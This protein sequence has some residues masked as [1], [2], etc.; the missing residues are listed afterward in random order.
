MAEL[1]YSPGAILRESIQVIRGVL[2]EELAELTVERVVFGLFFTGVKLG[3]GYC[4]VCYTPIKA[5]PEAVCCPSSARA[6][7]L[8]GKLK[9]RKA[10]ECMEEV[11]SA[12]PL[13]KTMGI[14]VM[15]ALSAICRDRTPPDYEVISGVDAFDEAVIAED[16]EVVVVG[17]LAPL[18]K[19]LKKRK[20]PF[21]VLEMDSS[22]LKKDELPFYAPAADAPLK[23]PQADVLV[24]TGT[25]LINDTLEGLLALAK[26]GAQVI[27]VGPT[28][29]MLP[30][31]FFLRGIKILG[32]VIGTRAD[33]LLD[34]IGEAGSGYHFFGKSA[35]RV[36]MKQ[37]TGR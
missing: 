36:V 12:N 35:E 3:N 31:A 27:V 8:S 10:A 33:E 2:G 26:P 32:G 23:V 17:A 1:D 29:S 15:N 9:G 37:R 28:A 24:I 20:R 14:A 30:D 4:G 11:A 21:C 13:K 16:D 22:T 19:V 18:L 7:P 25:T 6:M 34:I 5:I